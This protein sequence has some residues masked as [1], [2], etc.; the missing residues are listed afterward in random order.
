[1]METPISRSV[2]TKLR[3]I[4]ELAKED[5]ARS[6]LSLAHHID[7][8]FLHEAY[9][10]TRK[11]GAV[12]VDGQTAAQYAE[13]LEGNLEDLLNR[14]KAGTY[15]AP[16]VRRVYIP[17]GDGKKQRPL[18]IPTFEDKVL[19][20][21]VNMVLTAIYEED[22]KDSS[23]GFRPGRSAHE[24]LEALWG[25]I[26]KMGGGWVL[27]VDV[28]AFFDNLDHRKLR[29]IL[30]QRVRDGVLRRTI[31]KWLKAGILEDGELSRPKGGTPQGGVISPILANVYL[32]EVLDTWF[33]R[34]V[35]PRLRGEAF[36]VRYADDFVLVFSDGQDARRVLEVLPKRFARYGLTVHPEK[37]RLVRFRRPKPDSGGKGQD[38]D[39]GRPGS[40]DFLGFTLHWGRSRRGNWVVRRKTSSSRLSRA[41]KAMDR[42]CQQHRRL[43]VEEQYSQL[44]AKIRGHY[45]YYG[46]TGNYRSLGKFLAQTERNWKRWLDRRSQ[47]ARMSWERFRQLKKRFPLPRPRIVHSYV[48]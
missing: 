44:V 13:A 32:H 15:R 3:R 14:F 27:D 18:G 41:L 2:L 33:E 46:V 7:V 4:A 19:Q 39:G 9:E 29:E 28:Q 10:R 17:K 23:Y 11:D 8:K 40:F 20:M 37:T 22:F 42:W 30:D 25:G 48:T 6:F 43:P 12:G 47:K 21:A 31:D 26:M 24:A 16:P 5:P 36:L 38:S 1:M 34:D 45:A 35:Q